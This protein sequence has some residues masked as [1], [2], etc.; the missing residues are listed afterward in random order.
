MTTDPHRKWGNGNDDNQ[1]PG[2]M[3]FAD[4]FKK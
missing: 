1:V 3:T 4:Y 2:Q